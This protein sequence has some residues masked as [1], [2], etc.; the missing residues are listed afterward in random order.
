MKLRVQLRYGW[1]V[2]LFCL[3]SQSSRL[4]R[5]LSWLIMKPFILLLSQCQLMINWSSLVILMDGSTRILKPGMYL[6]ANGLKIHELCSELNLTICNSLY[7]K[8]LTY[9]I[10]RTHPRSEF[11]HMIHFL[12]THHHDISNVCIMHS[13]EC[14]TDHNLV[15]ERF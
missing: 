11:G 12:I 8:K 13:A 10:A 5:K 15:Y 7:C 6:D 3:H 2:T 9:K 1:Y 4:F 14:D